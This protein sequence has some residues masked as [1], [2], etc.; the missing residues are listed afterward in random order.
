MTRDTGDALDKPDK[1]AT[2]E[3]RDGN[4]PAFGPSGLTCTPNLGPFRMQLFE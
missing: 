3:N 4:S 1:E 2:N